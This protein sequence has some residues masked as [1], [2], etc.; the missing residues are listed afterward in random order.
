[1]A[2]FRCTGASGESTSALITRCAREVF[3]GTEVDEQRRWLFVSVVGGRAG[4]NPR[5][6][7]R[8]PG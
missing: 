1:M 6:S 7:D 4:I 8:V 5:R 2:T 3:P